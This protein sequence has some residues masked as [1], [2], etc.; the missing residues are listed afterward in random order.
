MT[1]ETRTPT[2]QAGY[3][4]D[5]L[6]VFEAQKKTLAEDKRRLDE[7]MA[8][9]KFDLARIMQESDMTVFGTARATATIETTEESVV[10]DW[11]DLYAHIIKTGDFDL[12]HRRLSSTAVAERMLAG[13]TVPGV[14]SRPVTTVKVRPTPRSA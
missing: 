6:L 7:A 5:L 11:G 2:Q 9:A 12:L 3:L 8:K 1:P 10:E 14:G 13:A 4:C